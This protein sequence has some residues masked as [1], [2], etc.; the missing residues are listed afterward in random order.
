MTIDF[1]N[2][3]VLELGQQ[4]AHRPDVLSRFAFPK[5]DT[6]IMTLHSYKSDNIIDYIRRA[7]PSLQSNSSKMV[8][9]WFR[10]YPGDTDGPLVDLISN[11]QPA[12]YIVWTIYRAEL[13]FLDMMYGIYG[14]LKCYGGTVHLYIS[15]FISETIQS[16]LED[17]VDS[18]QTFKSGDIDQIVARDLNPVMAKMVLLRLEDDMDYFGHE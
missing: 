9:R 2:L 10:E 15:Q 5:V 12:I 1:P 3:K 8:L 6:L 4:A 11:I 14:C 18:K 13:Y 7:I 17:R 16:V